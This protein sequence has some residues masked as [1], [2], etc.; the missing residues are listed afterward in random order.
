MAITPVVTAKTAAGMADANAL[1]TTLSAA[2][3]TT[4][5]TTSTPWGYTTQAQ[6]EL[7]VQLVIEMRQLLINAGI[8][9]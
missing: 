9:K 5:M 7:V 2:P 8:A 3:A 1:R 6:A 4:G